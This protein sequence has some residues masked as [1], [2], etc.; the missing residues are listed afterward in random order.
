MAGRVV[1]VAQQKGGAGKTTLAAQLAVAWAAAGVRVSVVDIDP[2][3]SLTQWAE[4]RRARLGDGGIG[5]EFAALPG[6]RATRWI[7]DQARH[8]DLVLIDGPPHAATEA[9]FAVRA[10]QWVLVPVQPSPLDLWATAATAKMVAEERR[11]LCAVLNRVPPRAGVTAQIAAALAGDGLAVAATRI[12]NRVAFAQAMEE[13]LGV[14]ERARTSPAATEI[15]A[16]A[17]ELRRL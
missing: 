14:T 6:W 7:A 17:E 8:A 2:Q 13:G 11:R 10:A 5:F 3:G 4:R 1:A 15:L 16:L 12:G 9:R